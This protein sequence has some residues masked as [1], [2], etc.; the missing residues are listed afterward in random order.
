MSATADPD[1]VPVCLLPDAECGDGLAACAVDV[2]PR[3]FGARSFAHSAGRDHYH[4]AGDAAHD[5]A[6]GDGSGTAEDDECDDAGNAGDHELEPACRV[7]I[8]LVRRTG[9]RDRA[10][11]GDE[12][13]VAG[14]R[15]A[16]DDGEA[17]AEEGEISFWP[18]AIG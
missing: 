5:T 1:A 14:A 8:I 10:A 15:D 18:L 12:S 16:R 3:S 13:H 6:G 9:D 2:G 17:G 11:G 7:G 4:H